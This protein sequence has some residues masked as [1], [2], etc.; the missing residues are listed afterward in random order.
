MVDYQNLVQYF[1]YDL[2]NDIQLVQSTDT[3]KC[4]LFHFE[5]TYDVAPFNNF[6]TRFDTT[7]AYEDDIEFIYDD[8]LF[9]IGPVKFT[10]QKKDLEK[11][12]NLKL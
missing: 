12:T 6:L 9:G 11:I 7:K 8:K 4:G 3:I 5:S 2:Q 10:I 1:S